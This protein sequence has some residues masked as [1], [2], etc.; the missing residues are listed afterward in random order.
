VRAVIRPPEVIARYLEAEGLP[1]LG[2][3]VL[4]LVDTGASRSR[5]RAGAGIP[6]KLGLL[7]GKAATVTTW[8]EVMECPTYEL[9]MALGEMVFEVTVFESPIP[10]RVY[11]AIVGRDV[12]GQCTFIYDGPNNSFTM[13]KNNQLKRKKRR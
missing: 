4:A 12:L 7:P 5:I 13:T 6:G 2:V 9:Q 11:D 10:G 1:V 3:P 8:D